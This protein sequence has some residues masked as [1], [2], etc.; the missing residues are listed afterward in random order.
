MM[1]TGQGLAAKSSVPNVNQASN[2]D[3]SILPRTIDVLLYD[4]VNAI[5]VSGPSQAFDHARHGDRRAYVLRY[6]SVDGAKVRAS[7]GLALAPDGCLS[8]DESSDLLVPGGAGVDE[9][10]QNTAV[11]EVLRTR[12]AHTDNRRLISICSG[13]LVLAAAGV[14]NGHTATTHW[15]RERD[16]RRFPGVMWDLDR[17]Y[18]ASGRIFTSAGVTTGIDLALAIIRNDCGN[19]AALTV[20]RELVVQLRRTGGQSQYAMHL[21]GQFAKEGGL[22]RLIETV[23]VDPSQRWTLDDLAAEAGM[24]RRTLSRVFQ[25]HLSV[26]PAQFVE[27]VR[28]DHARGLLED[29]LPLKLVATQ[30]GFGDVQRMRRAFQRRYGLSMAQYAAAFARVT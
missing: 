27:R 7:C 2:M 28:I 12:A 29:C 4:G 1:L 23:I 14:L 24:N 20:A 6:V 21:A 13:A 26:S 15:S 9:I 17:I 11:L 3:S 10:V 30:S 22:G 19:T 16:A 18:V 8:V 5:D 25:R